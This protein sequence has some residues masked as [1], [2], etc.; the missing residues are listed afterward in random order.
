MAP[1]V[2]QGLNLVHTAPLPS[3]DLVFPD[4]ASHLD[5][6][7]NLAFASDE[8]VH[9]NHDTHDDP[10]VAKHHPARLHD[11]DS[12]DDDTDDFDADD[13]AARDRS[14]ASHDAHINV[15]TGTDLP[16]HPS[17]QSLA[18]SP[19]F[20][21]NAFLAGFGIDPFAVPSV[22]SQPQ[23]PQPESLPPLNGH[24]IAH[25]LALHP[26]APKAFHPTST[27]HSLSPLQHN[28]FIPA[29][30]DAPFKRPR[31]SSVSTV[32]SNG[33]YRD[34]SAPPTAKAGSPAS[35]SP[36][37]DKR[38]RNTAASARFRMKKKEREAALEGRA[39]ELE[40]KVNDLERECESLRRENGWLKG[41]VVGVTGAASQP[42]SQLP[43]GT[44][45]TKRNREENL[46]T[47]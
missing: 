34:A 32:D 13:L 36:T 12:P 22:Q 6:W 8:P 3:Q 31:K 4:I 41:L 37:E 43:Q 2:L 9:R 10:T 27:V 11:A 21:L 29:D 28:G 46:G 15:V 40:T 47:S 38:R 33:D 25:L 44:S 23:S 26:A 20:D 14:A 42:H 16:A 35:L 5:L 39:K 7:T 17:A 24:S 19:S 1:S 30:I 18:Q 45:G